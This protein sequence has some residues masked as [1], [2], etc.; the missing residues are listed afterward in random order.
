VS[1]KK[2]EIIFEAPNAVLDAGTFQKIKDR[3]EDALTNRVFVAWLLRRR[4]F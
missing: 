4:G 1:D 3:R 2:R